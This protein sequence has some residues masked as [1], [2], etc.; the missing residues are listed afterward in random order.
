MSEQEKECTP[1][2]PNEA[3]LK[4]ENGKVPKRKV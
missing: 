2:V 4:V 1:I 3:N